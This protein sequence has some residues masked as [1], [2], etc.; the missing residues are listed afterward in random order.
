MK[1]GNLKS[2]QSM[3]GVSVSLGEGKS[4]LEAAM[5]NFKLLLPLENDKNKVDGLTIC[6][7]KRHQER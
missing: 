5:S 7:D 2:T 1:V 6:V 4:S 3:S